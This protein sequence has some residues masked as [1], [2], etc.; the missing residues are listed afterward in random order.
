MDLTK[1]YFYSL[2]KHHNKN[3]LVKTH[4]Y[5]GYIDIQKDIPQTDLLETAASIAFDQSLFHEIY[6]Y[7]DDS[8]FVNQRTSSFSPEDLMSNL[9]GTYAGRV[10]ITSGQDFDQEAETALRDILIALDAL[11]LNSTLEGLTKIKALGWTSGGFMTGNTYL[12]R[13]NF[14]FNPVVPWKLTGIPGANDIG[15]PAA[16]PLSFSVN[17]HSSYNIMIFPPYGQSYIGTDIMQ[18]KDISVYIDQ[19]KTHARAEYG[20]NYDSP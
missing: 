2:N 1:F 17:I 14:N 3:D 4:P 15:I 8:L 12:Q 6:T 11:P 16:I 18:S 5:K 10:A 9:L 7:W 19:V 20:P 13:R